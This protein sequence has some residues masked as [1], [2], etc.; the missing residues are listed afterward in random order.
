MNA[1][2]NPVTN[3]GVPTSLNDAINGNVL[4]DAL[5]DDGNYEYKFIYV[6]VATYNGNI[7]KSGFWV[8]GEDSLNP[9]S[10]NY[11]NSMS[12]LNTYLST[13][14]NNGWEIKFNNWY[15]CFYIRYGRIMVGFK[16]RN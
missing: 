2:G 10:S 11:G 13:N 14:F 1:N 4:Q 12:N 9:S 15:W 7:N 3:V 16:K 8:L 5:R 6:N